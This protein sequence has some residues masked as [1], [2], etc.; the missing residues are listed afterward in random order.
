MTGEFQHPSATW[1]LYDKIRSGAVHGEE[2]PELDWQVTAR[3][4]WSVREVLNQYL[5]CAR[6]HNITRR[7]K[8]LKLLDEHPDRKALIA[9]LRK[10]TGSE[11]TKYLDVLDWP[12]NG[13]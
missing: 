4:E 7:G 1:F 12:E 2:V 9:W 8:L 13:C 5:D 3:A 10:N 6:Q 11:W